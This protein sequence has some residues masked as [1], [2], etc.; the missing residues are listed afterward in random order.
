MEEEGLMFYFTPNPSVMCIMDKTSTAY[1]F[2]NHI[3][4]SLLGKYKDHEGKVGLIANDI[5]AI[6]I[7]IFLILEGYYEFLETAFLRKPHLICHP[8]YWN[9]DWE[10]DP[11]D[12]TA[13]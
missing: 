2:S 5:E 9:W 1:R 11:L 10:Q 6:K 8:K 12:I 3:L 13:K 7:S 4:E